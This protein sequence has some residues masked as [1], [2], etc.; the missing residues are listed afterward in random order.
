VTTRLHRLIA[1]AIAATL[2][3]GT[4]QADASTSAKSGATSCTV[5]AVKPTLTTT[6]QLTGSATVVCTAAVAITVEV[7]V[8]ELDGTVEDPTVLMAVKKLAISAAKNVT[9]TVPTATVTCI[10]TETGNE[11]Y[12]SK[13]RVSLSGLVSTYDR[14]VP[15]ND[16][17]AC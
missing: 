10:S 17:F 8:V 1:P 7:T 14:T 16:S 4:P 3:L 9:Y 13:A 15:L 6:K 5:T 2:L 11:E 12:A